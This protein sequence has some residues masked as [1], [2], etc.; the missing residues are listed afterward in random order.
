MSPPISAMISRRQNSGASAGE[1]LYPKGP[2]HTR[3][4][5][6]DNMKAIREKERQNRG[7]QMMLQQK[8]AEPVELFKL[9]RFANAKARLND[10]KG[11]LRAVGAAGGGA[12]TP[13]EGKDGDNMKLEDFED[14]VAKLI[15]NHGNGGQKQRFSKDPSGCPSYLRKMK[16][17]AAEQ[18][19][20]EEERKN[21][22]KCPAGYRIMPAE[23]VAETLSLLKKKHEEI[24]KEYRMLPLKIETDGQKRRQKMVLEKIEHSNKAIA[25]FSKPTVMVEA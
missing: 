16:E 20:A 9:K 7:K 18:K 5:A 25:M 4:H 13:E 8:A 1:L 23:E 17:D 10:P 11:Q 3:N 15:K 24:E 22:P 14:E 19:R 6:R 21:Q 2:T 12:V